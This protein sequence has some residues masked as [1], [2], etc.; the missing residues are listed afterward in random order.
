VAGDATDLDALTDGLAAAHARL[1]AEPT[2]ASAASHDAFDAL[3]DYNPTRQL[4]DVSGL[5]KRFTGR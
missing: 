2:D 5:R 4:F 1:L 3:K